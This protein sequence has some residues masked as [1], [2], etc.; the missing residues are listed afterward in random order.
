MTI[1]P[2]A[3]KTCFL[4]TAHPHMAPCRVSET[5]ILTTDKNMLDRC[6][7]AGN[8]GSHLAR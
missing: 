1:R 4:R 2:T 8:N 5:V 6:E 7:P 3:A